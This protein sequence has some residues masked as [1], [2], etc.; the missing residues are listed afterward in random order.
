MNSPAVTRLDAQVDFAWDD[1][2]P[3]PG[4]GADW[5]TARWSWEVQA[6]YSEAYTFRTRN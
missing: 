4:V 1:G 5:F 3:A 6:Q 2:T